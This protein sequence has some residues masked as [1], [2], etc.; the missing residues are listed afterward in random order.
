MVI[1]FKTSNFVMFYYV[2]TFEIITSDIPKN[3]SKLDVLKIMRNGLQ[4]GC[5]E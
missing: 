4:N 3:V 1:Y 5:S 2:Y